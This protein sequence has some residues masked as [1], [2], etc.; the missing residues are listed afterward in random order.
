MAAI[1]GLEN[2]GTVSFDAGAILS[3]VVIGVEI[4]LG[5]LV[6]WGLGYFLVFKKMKYKD[7]IEVTDLTT[8]QKY[9]DRG[10][11]KRA[12]DGTEE[13]VLMKDKHA[14][15]EE[16]PASQFVSPRGKKIRQLAKYGA[17]DYNWANIGEKWEKSKAK[18]LEYPVTNLTDQNWT[19]D[20]IKRAA[21]KRD[22]LSGIKAYL[23][24]IMIGAVIVMFIIAAWFLNG[25]MQQGIATAGN[26]MS[27]AAEISQQNADTA[28]LLAGV[29]TGGGGAIPPP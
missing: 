1:P 16:P 2:V 18:I 6:I 28:R 12:K 20:R 9:T 15:L 13:Y 14:K 19:R 3:K 24:Q 8:M 23:P 5:L 25:T 10:Y 26:T 4:V 7:I 29:T 22:K 21:E 11:L 17:G 27:K